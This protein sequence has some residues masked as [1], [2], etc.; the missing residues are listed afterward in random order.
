MIFI[1]DYVHFY[2]LMNP[3]GDSQAGE[4]DCI[5]G[6]SKY[7]ENAHDKVRFFCAIYM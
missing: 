4:V 6:D 3:G 5:Q 7:T 1:K 2:D